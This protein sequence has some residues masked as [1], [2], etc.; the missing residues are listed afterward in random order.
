MDPDGSS[1]LHNSPPP[2]PNLSKRNPIHAFPFYFLKIDFNTIHPRTL[3]SAQSLSCRF[4][5][6]SPIT[7]QHN[8]WCVN[9]SYLTSNALPNSS[10]TKRRK[11]SVCELSL[12]V[13]GMLKIYCQQRHTMKGPQ[14]IFACV[15]LNTVHVE[16]YF[17]RYRQC[18]YIAIMRRL[19]R[20]NCS[21]GKATIPVH[22]WATRHGQ[23]Y[24]NMECCT[25]ML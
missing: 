17:T 4:S 2:F 18:T 24:K 23:W 20:N 1:C 25:N 10:W 7:Y 11:I 22:S 6:Q 8:V 12:H 5:N 9:N 15:A 13:A 14:I 16:T 3:P 21:N 19:T